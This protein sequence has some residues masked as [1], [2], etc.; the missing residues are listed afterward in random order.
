MVL[1]GVAA[2]SMSVPAFAASVPEQMVNQ[3]QETVCV[4][5]TES[6]E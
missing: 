4:A 2:M 3:A 5:I 6:A 1:A